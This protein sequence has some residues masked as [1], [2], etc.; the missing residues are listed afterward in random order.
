LA[1]FFTYMHIKVTRQDGQSALRLFYAMEPVL[2]DP[3][4]GESLAEVEEAAYA[5][6]RSHVRAIDDSEDSLLLTYLETALDYMEALTNR[7]L[8]LS[9][10]VVYV[11]RDELKRPFVVHR[12]QDVLRLWKLEYRSLD[13]DSVAPWSKPYKMFEPTLPDVVISTKLA[14][15]SDTAIAMES[16][17]KTSFNMYLE[18]TSTSGLTQI[19]CD[20]EKLNEASGAYVNEGENQVVINTFNST[21]ILI[22]SATGQGHNHERGTYRWKIQVTD[23]EEDPSTNYLYFTIHNGTDFDN[24]IITDRY[25]CYFDL[26]KYEDAIGSTELYATDEEDFARIY[27]IAGTDLMAVPR[28]YRQAALLLVG[29]YYNMREAENIGSITTEVKEGVH[30]L[31][32]S[33]RQY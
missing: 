2:E 29:H 14:G 17:D 27:M 13:A 4:E 28:Q 20:L 26:S 15:L 9:D 8:G 25:P 1:P 11:N 30:R 23:S 6:L 19:L 32:Q 7:I 22:H 31:L 3:A 18:L 10:V 24:I 16:D 12:V 5:L 33:V 21:S